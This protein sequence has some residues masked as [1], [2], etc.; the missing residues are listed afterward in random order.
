MLPETMPEHAVRT[1]LGNMVAVPTIGTAQLLA[2]V[3]FHPQ[4]KSL[5]RSRWLRALAEQGRHH[6]IESQS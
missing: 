3:A 1:M 5:V 6:G 4:V 2:L